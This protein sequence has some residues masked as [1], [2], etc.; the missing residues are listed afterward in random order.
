V[1]IDPEQRPR[2]WLADKLPTLRHLLSSRLVSTMDRGGVFF[3][4]RA[5]RTTR[6]ARRCC[7]SCDADCA[8]RG[9]CERVKPPGATVVTQNGTSQALHSDAALTG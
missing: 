2:R 6:C 8:R 4:E 3:E 9:T 5:R 7:W 1:L